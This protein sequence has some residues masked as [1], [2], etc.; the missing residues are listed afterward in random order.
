[1]NA[2]TAAKAL[3]AASVTAAVAAS[4]FGLGTD[5]ACRVQPAATWTFLAVLLLT[6]L[7]GRLFCEC[8]C[9]LGFVQSLV[10]LVF[11][12]RTKVRRVCT[13]LPEGR[14]QRV[15]RWT[16][17]ALFAALAAS[18]FGAIA[19]CL[20]PYSI[21]GKALTLFWPGVA[22]FGLVAVLA[23]AGKGRFWCN[24]ICPAGTLF[25]VLSRKS[26]CSHKVGRGC[27]NCRACFGNGGKSE[28]KVGDGEKAIPLSNSNSE[29]QLGPSATRREALKGVAALAAVEAAEKTT[30][31]GFAP[32]SLPGVPNR[33]APVLPPGAVDRGKFNVKCVACGL[34]IANCRG[35]CLSASTSFRRFGQPEMDFRRGYCLV[36]CN[37]ACGHVC[38]TGAINWIPRIERKNVHMGHAIWRKDLCIRET[39]GVEYTAC[40]RKC[41][42]KAIHVV[43]GF[44]VVDRDACIGCGACEHVCPVRPMP[45]IFVKG[46]ERQRIVWPMDPALAPPSKDV[47]DSAPGEEGRRG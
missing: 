39:E 43:E 23:A 46:F 32:V 20:T 16:V 42:V 3:V 34:C 24:W 37:Y 5:I 26:V 15:V 33:P 38:P 10:N 11:H 17:L 2:K 9:P 7:A 30:D 8:L 29:L 4:F 19:W 12:P 41:P 14:A 44:P 28:A 47:R 36:G 6:P 18:G 40:S 1:M 21:F 25:S 13:R 35:G 22:V 45:A 31:G 27:A